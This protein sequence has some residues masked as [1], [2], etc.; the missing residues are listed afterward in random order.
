MGVAIASA[1]FDAG[2]DVTL[3]AGPL[4]IDIPKGIK[5]IPVSTAAEMFEASKSIFAS[6][7]GAVLTAA[8]ADY[9]PETVATDKVKKK[10]AQWTL[11]LVKTV[12]IAE[13][14]GKLKLPKQVLMGFALETSNEIANAQAKL[15]KKNLDLIVLN[16]LKDEGAG[17]GTDTNK[18]T[19]IG[20]NL[21]QEFPLKSKV[22]VAEDIVA[23][24]IQ[25]LHA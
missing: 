20:D 9:T 24:I 13:E 25:L 22:G 16:S 12:D 4:Q 3:V 17:F 18:I 21:I 11:P 15:K 8:V 7:T 2:A 14:L 19:F 1:L 10:E 6:Q 23:K 5:H